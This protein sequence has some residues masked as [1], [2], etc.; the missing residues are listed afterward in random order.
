MVAGIIAAT[1]PTAHAQTKANG[2]ENSVVKVFSSVRHPDLARPWTKQPPREVTGSGV[3]IEGKR[4][5][6]NAHVVLYAS[7][8]QA[9]A[10]EAGDKFSAT[11]EFIAPGLDLAVLKLEDESFFDSHPP[12]PRATTLPKVKD[13]VMAYG[14]PR[15]GASLS[16]T[17]GIISRLEF[18]PYSYGIS[19][20]RIQIDAAINPGNSGGPAVVNDKMI[21]LAF[22][23]LVGADNIGY[24]I[25]NEEIELFL[26]DIADGHYDGK[27]AICDAFQTL[28]NPAL[29][30]FLKLGNEVEGL[31]VHRPCSSRPTYPLKKWDV[32]TRI[33]DTALDN[34]G[35][36]KLAGTNLRV[37][38][39]YLIQKSPRNGTIPLTLVRAGK[40]LEV[41]LPL[42]SK[43]PGVMPA[44]AGT[45]PSYFVYGALV[46]S[47]A[48]MDHVHDLAVG[49]YGGPVLEMLGAM[50]SPLVRRLGDRAGCKGESLVVVSSP[51]FPHK[52]TKGYDNPVSRVVRTVNGV[53]IKNLA[54][55]VEVLRDSNDEF[56]TIDFDI[57]GAETL[58]FPRRDVVAA[59]D[60]ILR[61]NGVRSQG[62]ADMLAIWN[63]N[64]P[65]LTLRRGDAQ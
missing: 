21:G 56:V 8:M 36:V 11:V 58:V 15:G 45:Y 42:P 50:G 35:M 57:R 43:E 34:R 31:V 60:E 55:L 32:I 13:A 29:R 40:S 10:N 26:Q 49:N 27:A 24:I 19:G 47:S 53:P 38:F 20:L 46:F 30:S 3:V 62:S 7:E 18:A 5:L 61:D 4:I 25:P 1:L 33:G 37:S 2:T 48:T 17:R 12:L 65:E 51:F 54:N 59:T 16:I 52:L 44:L 39:R 64:G 22:S 63:A 9:Q 14:Y 6:S 23:R 28:E 41:E